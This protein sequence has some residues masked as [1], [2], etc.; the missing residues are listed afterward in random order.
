MKYLVFIVLLLV[1]GSSA[2]VHRPI[3]D[4]ALKDM[5]EA[6]QN[7][8]NLLVVVFTSSNPEHKTCQALNQKLLELANSHSDAA[9]FVYADVDEINGN[10]MK[11]YIPGYVML[12]GA[13]LLE[14]IP[15]ATP[16][17]FEDSLNSY[18]LYN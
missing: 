8:S 13:Q 1:I 7:G 3:S 5:V 16:Q 6:N 11:P 12:R 18:I 2:L 14:T 9:T 17:Q 10:D 15:L 4:V